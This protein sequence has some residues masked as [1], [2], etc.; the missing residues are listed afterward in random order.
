MTYKGS[1]M[2]HLR[3]YVGCCYLY[4]VG[5]RTPLTEQM[6]AHD[7]D[8]SWWVRPRPTTAATT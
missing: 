2:R 6:L 1:V 7:V 5:R 8:V 3:R 4:P